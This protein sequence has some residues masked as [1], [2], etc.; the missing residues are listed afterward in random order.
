MHHPNAIHQLVGFLHLWNPQALE[1]AAAE[2][3]QLARSG[4]YQPGVDFGAT[5]AESPAGDAEV[6]AMLSLVPALQAEAD[7][8]M[9]Y[10]STRL[11]RSARASFWCEILAAVGSGG[12]LGAAPVS[13]F[14]WAVYLGASVALLSSIFSIIARSN[15]GV[16]GTDFLKTYQ[17][18]GSTA[19]SIR[20]RIG[21]LRALAGGGDRQQHDTKFAEVRSLLEVLNGE[22]LKVPNYKP[23]S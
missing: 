6:D 20:L 1:R 13:G 16:A 11:A 5:T 9:G 21:E 14:V 2:N 3:P 17:T 23:I 18:I 10:I 4:L 7:R 19:F 22:L 8:A 12:A 15:Q